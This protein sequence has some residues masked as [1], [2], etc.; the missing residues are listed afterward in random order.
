MPYVTSSVI[1]RVEYDP[2]AAELQV[3][4]HAKGGPYAYRRVP[5]ELYEALLAAPSI[6]GFFNAEIR[7]RYE[8]SPPA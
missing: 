2:D 6:G 8:F 1:A 5:E 4:F 3:W 7:D